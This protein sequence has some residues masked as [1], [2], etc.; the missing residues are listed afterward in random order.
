MN[1]L[2]KSG[3][4]KIRLTIEINFMSSKDIDEESIMHSKSDNIEIMIS[5]KA[6]EVTEE[7]FRSRLSRYEFSMKDTGFIFGCIYSFTNV[8]K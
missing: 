1:N 3:V 8:A 2:K 7:L 5:D 6:D 4:W